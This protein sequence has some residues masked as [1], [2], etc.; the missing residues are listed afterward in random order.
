[1][2]VAIDELHRVLV[3][4]G[5]AMDVLMHMVVAV[6]VVVLLVQVIVIVFVPVH[7]VAVGVAGTLLPAGVHVT[8]LARV[9][10]L[11]LDQV[12]DERG[13]RGSEHDFSAD[14]GRAEETHGSFVEEP[15]SHEPDRKDGAEGTHDLDAM[16]AERVLRIRH[17]VGDVQRPYRDAEAYDIR[18]DVRRV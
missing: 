18:G 5:V 17:R 15:R 13:D 10:D 11:D 4:M 14:F 6:T 8:A 2:I 9:Q 12:K 3:R 16:V 7:V 1:M